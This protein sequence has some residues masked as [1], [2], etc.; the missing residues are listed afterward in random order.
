MYISIATINIESVVMDSFTLDMI[1]F[2]YHI[3]KRNGRE[4]ERNNLYLNEKGGGE[5]R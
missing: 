2:Y 3:N 1:Y 5:E 4:R